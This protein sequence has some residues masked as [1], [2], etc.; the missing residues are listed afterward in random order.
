M[1]FWG[2]LKVSGF[3]REGKGRLV[4]RSDRNVCKWR[5]RDGKV[6][7]SMGKKGKVSKGKVMEGKV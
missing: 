3:E 1:V 7:L 5:V 6:R 2:W 4:K